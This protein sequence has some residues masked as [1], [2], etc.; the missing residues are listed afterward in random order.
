M[1]NVFAVRADSHG[2]VCGD[3]LRACIARQGSA[4]A[5]LRELMRGHLRK[6][7]P[8]RDGCDNCLE[9]DGEHACACRATRCDTVG[10]RCSRGP[11]TMLLPRGV[12]LRSAF[13]LRGDL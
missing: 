12:L 10:V 8:F 4:L 11:R 7:I 2:R 1:T 9:S 13:R 6:L 3:C 5:D